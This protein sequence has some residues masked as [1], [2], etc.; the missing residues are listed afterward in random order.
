VTV[1]EVCG[2]GSHGNGEHEDDPA[3][4]TLAIPQY[5]LAKKE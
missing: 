2:G 3:L 1:A 5:L 4:I